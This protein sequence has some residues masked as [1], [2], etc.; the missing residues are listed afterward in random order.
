MLVDALACVPSSADRGWSSTQRLRA[1]W[2][3][4]CRAAV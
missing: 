2:F 3:D 4:F 1:L